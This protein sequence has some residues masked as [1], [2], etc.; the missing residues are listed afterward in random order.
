MQLQEFI[1]CGSVPECVSMGIT[2]FVIKEKTKGNGAGNYTLK[3]CL[4][5][6]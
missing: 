3:T 5:I 2:A 1:E 6:M 4:E